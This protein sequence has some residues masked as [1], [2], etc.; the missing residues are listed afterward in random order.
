MKIGIIGLP[1]VGKKTLFEL[2]TGEKIE[3]NFSAKS[4]TKIG[5]AVIRDSR[6]DQL[7]QMYQPKKVVPATI[8]VVLL[9]K[10]DKETVQ[11]GEFIRSLENCDAL[12]QVV[13]GFQDETIFHVEG[14]IDPLRD[15]DNVMTELI[16]GDLILVEKRLGRL[17]KELMNKK[18]PQQEKEKEILIRMK[19]FL[20]DQRPLS[21]LE[22]SD[23][24][25]KGMATY[26]FL[27]RKPMII[28]LNVDDQKLNDKQLPDQLLSAHQ[29]ADLKVMQIS[30]KIEAEISSLDEEE[31]EVFLND[32][33][34]KESALNRLTRLCYESLGLMTF[35]TVGPTEVHAWITKK[36][37]RTPV[38]AGVIHSDMQRGFIRAE[39]MKSDELIE[40]QSESQ[41]KEEG[42]VY[43]KGKDYVL[44]DGDVMFVRFNV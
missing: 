30:A 38:A 36:G 10:F 11:S 40:A 4:G 2:L 17:T 22:L 25:R 6:F 16:L 21:V 43:L 42:K 3:E 15:I 20:D 18:T 9:P 5:L 24:E 1:N 44:E 41:L 13:R 19:S 31:R 29:D 7:V 35:F 37:S 33:N 23:E 27:T 12:C 14:S 39:I 28:V 32:L 34:I 8:E 26:K